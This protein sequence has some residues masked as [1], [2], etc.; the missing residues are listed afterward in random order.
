M[1]KWLLL[2][3]ST[4]AQ[5]AEWHLL[6]PTYLAMESAKIVNHN[7]QYFGYNDPGQAPSSEG[8]EVWDH[9]TAV[10]WNLDLVTYHSGSGVSGLYWNNTV[11]G[12]STDHQFRT[13]SWQWEAGLDI[14]DKFQFFWAHHSQHVLD[15]TRD[16]H[17]PLDNFIGGRVVFLQRTPR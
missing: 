5:A 2:I 3:L 1:W 7:D 10:S 13:V 4:Q 17:F 12:A 6:E 8:T 9:Y 11:D 14:Q 15:T 16:S